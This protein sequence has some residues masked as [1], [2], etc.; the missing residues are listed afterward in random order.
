MSRPLDEIVQ[1]YRQRQQELGPLHAAAQE[2]AMTY[3]GDFAIPLPEL[4]KDERRAVPNLLKQGLDQLSMRISSVMPD[5]FYPPDRPG[6]KNSEEF[7]RIRRKANLGWWEHSN[8]KL[9]DGRRAR[10]LLGYATSPVVIKPDFK[11]GVPSWQLRHPLCSYPAKTMNPDDVRP[12]DCIFT[13]ER[14]LGWLQRQYPEMYLGLAKGRQPAPDQKIT[15]LEYLDAEETVLIVLGEKPDANYPGNGMQAQAELERVPNR[16]G[17]CPAVV[18]GRITL[19]RRQGA[20]D[21]MIGLYQRQ[22]KLMAL[23]VIAVEQGVFPDEWL[24]AR[25]NETP[26]IVQA[27]DGRMGVMGIVRGG[28]V[29]SQTNNPSYRTEQT[30]NMLERAQRLE[31]GIPAEFG[32]ECYDLSAEILT[33]LGWRSYDQIM[34]G[35]EVLTLNHETGLSEWQPLQAI[36]VFAA[37]PREMLSCE[38]RAFSSLTT[39]NHRWPVITRD[40]RRTWTTSAEMT[41][42][43]RVVLGASNADLPTEPKFSDALV[44]V[45]AWY[46]TEGTRGTSNISIAKKMESYPEHYERIGSALRQLFGP[47]VDPFPRDGGKTVCW[48]ESKLNATTGVGGFYLSA[49]ASDIIIEHAPG[50]EKVPTTEFLRALTQAQLELF[51]AVSLMAD[52]CG[53][54]RFGQVSR[55]RAEAFGFAAI[56]AGYSVTYRERHRSESRDEFKRDNY[57]THIARIRKTRQVNP[58][59]N[60]QRGTATFEK[61]VREEPVWCPTTPNGTWLVRRGG[62]IHFTGNSTTNVRTGRRG[63]AILSAVVD[64][65]VQEAQRIFEVSKEAENRVAVATARGY[66]GKQ[67]KSFYVNWKGA[68]GVV[69]Y[70]PETHFKSDANIVTYAHAGADVNSLIIGIGQ[71]IGVGLISTELGRELNPMI[72][73]PEREHDR[74]TTEALEKA[75]L[76]SVQ[77]GAVSGQIAP[78]D[79]ARIMELVGENRKTLVEAVQQVQEEVQARQATSGAPGTPEAAVAPGA[80]EAQ[81]GLGAPGSSAPAGAI[82]PTPDESGLA[83]LMAALRGGAAA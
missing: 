47:P 34:V 39:M 9:M 21:G 68:K 23:E 11:A 2:V 80:P 33:A 46:W 67:P 3:S 48:R 66:F 31:A 38:G 20:F 64:F 77:Q 61:K 71:M 30:I 69:D 57:V 56:L 55:A 54:G 41:S 7:A 14:T 35:D 76:A 45:V 49:R 78:A 43:H 24:V 37:E 4:D 17:V 72:D 83:G 26:A 65:P 81:P 5:V 18:P 28:E 79:L 58:A 63:D 32:G 73:D 1:L 12:D 19:D 10:H 59:E 13:Y 36:N 6:F 60:A 62:T 15:L 52:N 82:Q 25:P 29:H 8:I 51:L 27:A 16:A 75:L 22:A 42:T 74:V 70:T 53:D 50:H 40:G 44:E